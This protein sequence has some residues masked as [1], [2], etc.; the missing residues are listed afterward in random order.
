MKTDKS[1]KYGKRTRTRV[2]VCFCSGL[3]ACVAWFCTTKTEL[4]VRVIECCLTVWFTGIFPHFFRWLRFGKPDR[5]QQQQ[6]LQH[7]L[8]WYLPSSGDSFYPNFQ[9]YDWYLSQWNTNMDDMKLI[10]GRRIDAL[11]RWCDDRGFFSRDGLID[12]VGEVLSHYWKLTRGLRVNK[13]S[14]KFIFCYSVI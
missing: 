4:F 6:Q 2:C 8:G 5:R 1:K 12:A 13:V 11:F 10:N 7:W 14:L 9:I 3:P